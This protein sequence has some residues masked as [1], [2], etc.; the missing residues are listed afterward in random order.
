MYLQKNG[1]CVLTSDIQLFQFHRYSVT[2]NMKMLRPMLKFHR[3][4]QWVRNLGRKGIVPAVEYDTLSE[5]RKREVTSTKN[6]FLCEDHFEANQFQDPT[7]KGK[8][9]V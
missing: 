6:L 8:F 9:K 5:E 7:E 3:C 4:T 1:I 2:T